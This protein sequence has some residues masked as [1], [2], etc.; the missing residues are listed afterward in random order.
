MRVNQIEAEIERF[1]DE[2]EAASEEDEIEEISSRLG[3][4]YDVKDNLLQEAESRC[5]QMLEELNFEN[6][7]KCHFLNSR[8]DGNTNASCCQH[9]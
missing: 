9:F 6:M 4:A 2:L 8:Q 3:D 5:D 7:V 1:E